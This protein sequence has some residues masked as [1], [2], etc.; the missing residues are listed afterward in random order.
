METE[1]S[2]SIDIQ[3]FI[4]VSARYLG[5]RADGLVARG[6]WDTAPAT[7][8]S[9]GVGPCHAQRCLTIALGPPVR[10]S[11]NWKPRR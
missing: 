4:A 1:S 3:D 6:D 2:V 5:L 9:R 10:S 7:A 8:A 11:L